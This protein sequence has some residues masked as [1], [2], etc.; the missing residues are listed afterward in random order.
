MA[1]LMTIKTKL[2]EVLA[3]K[4]MSMYRLAEDT[5]IAYTTIYKL[6]KGKTE[7]IQFSVLNRICTRLECQPGDLI[8]HEPDKPV[9]KGSA[10]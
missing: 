1:N 2:A 6:A 7:G 10:K 5:G 9:R 3:G 8:I 4:D